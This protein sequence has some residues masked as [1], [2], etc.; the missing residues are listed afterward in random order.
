MKPIYSSSANNVQNETK[1]QQ[2][3]VKRRKKRLRQRQKKRIF[4]EKRRKIRE[5]L[6]VQIDCQLKN[7]RETERFSI[8]EIESQKKMMININIL[9]KKILEAHSYIN[10]LNS[11]NELRTRRSK[12]M[13]LSIDSC[14]KNYL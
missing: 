8:Q 6:H 14:E 9:S 4:M 5:D 12:L 1:F 13:N 2:L 3:T 7:L 10:K 11:L